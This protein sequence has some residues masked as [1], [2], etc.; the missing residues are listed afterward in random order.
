MTNYELINLKTLDVRAVTVLDGPSDL[1]MFENVGSSSVNDPSNQSEGWII[2]ISGAALSSAVATVTASYVYEY[3]PTVS[4]LPALS[5]SYPESGPAT[6]PFI[7]TLIKAFPAVLALEPN[8]ARGLAT[9]ILNS[10]IRSHDALIE[11]VLQECGALTMRAR[12]S[13]PFYSN[14][15][16]GGQDFALVS[17]NED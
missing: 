7:S 6:I 17:E 3:L 8:Q 14:P 13:T 16:Q 5:V 10:G 15:M 4:A 12:S 9:S 1:T 11:F 2:I